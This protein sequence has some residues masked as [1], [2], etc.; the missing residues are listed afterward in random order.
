MKKDF[1]DQI[2]VNQR[3]MVIMEDKIR[4]YFKTQQQ[5]ELDGYQFFGIAKSHQFSI[6]ASSRSNMLYKT[7]MDTTRAVYGK[8]DEDGILSMYF[9]EGIPFN[10]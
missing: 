1:A 5:L 3:E 7:H 9:R 6:L 4:V 8:N 2:V 10:L